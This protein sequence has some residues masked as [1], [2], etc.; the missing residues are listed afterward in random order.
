ML[1]EAVS[2]HPL[3]SVVVLS[4]KIS[5][6]KVIHKRLAKNGSSP[7][8]KRL[9]FRHKRGWARDASSFSRRFVIFSRSTWSGWELEHDFFCGLFSFYRSFS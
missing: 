5:Y 8:F 9:D 1:E 2:S 4:L 6:L 3:N 7:V